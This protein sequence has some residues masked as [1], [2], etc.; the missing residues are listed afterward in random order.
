MI[1]L[2]DFV[3]ELSETASLD[4]VMEGNSLGL[5]CINNEMRIEGVLLQHATDSPMTDFLIMGTF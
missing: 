5:D 3:H 4:V 1:D 2:D